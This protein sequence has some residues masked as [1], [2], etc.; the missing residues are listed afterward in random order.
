MKFI[1]RL[2][3]ISLATMTAMAFLGASSAMAEPEHPEIVLCE[4]SE[5]ICEHQAANPTEIHFETLNSE[6]PKLLTSLGTIECEKS[7][8]I[9][10]L[11]N[12][13]A[14]LIE[15]HL[16]AFNLTGCKLGG[17]ACTAT[18]NALGGLSLTPSELKLWAIA[19]PI[20]L[21]GRNTNVTFK[22]GSLVNCTYSASEATQ[23]RPNRWKQ[24]NSYT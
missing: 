17:T 8:I 23:W 9:M 19:R 10:T 2:G 5:L 7:L 15:A 22:C 13:L 14:K 12:K 3:L 11:L 1:K 21:E 6:P 18:V 4:K 24:A 20:E 16:L